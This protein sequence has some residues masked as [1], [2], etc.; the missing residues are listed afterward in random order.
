M[1]NINHLAV[2][3]KVHY[4]P[5]HYGDSRWENGVIKEIRI[6]PLEPYS[7]C[8]DSV[9]VV[10]NCAEDW[11]NYK[12]YTSAKTNLRDLKAGWR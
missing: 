4:Q 1:L 11:A 7:P 5:K 6:D 9:W 8:L 12:N 10:Y 3:D 2:G